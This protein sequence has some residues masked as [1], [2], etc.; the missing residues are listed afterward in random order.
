VCE[1][2][3]IH[4]I[5]RASEHNTCTQHAIAMYVQ[6]IDES[7][8]G[9]VNATVFK[10]HAHTHTHLHRHQTLHAHQ[11]TIDSEP[12]QRH[13]HADQ[14][15]ILQTYTHIIGDV[16]FQV[17]ANANTLRTCTPNVIVEKKVISQIANSGRLSRHSGNRS[18][19]DLH[20]ENVFFK[21]ART[22]T[23]SL[24]QRFTCDDDDRCQ[25]GSW[26]CAQRRRRSRKRPQCMHIQH[27]HTR[28]SGLKN[29]VSTSS[30]MQMSM[31]T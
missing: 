12:E 23:S 21:H 13:A 17:T 26:L 2:V 7:S 27:K 29:G 28:T 31:A 25:H 4:H 9:P 10:Q 8:S 6:E 20:T 30:V 16:V 5:P 22:R 3:V 15:T 1:C 11:R 14:D 24:P 18:P 19:N